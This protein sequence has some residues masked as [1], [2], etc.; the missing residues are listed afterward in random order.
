MATTIP[1]TP[2]VQLPAGAPE[3]PPAPESTPAS[4]PRVLIGELTSSASALVLLIV[5]FATKWYGVAGVPDPSAAR[6]AVSTAETGWEGL[7]L[8]RW[9]VLVT[10]LGALGTVLLHASQRRHGAKTDTSRLILGLG[11]LSSVLLIYRVL[12][13][14]PTGGRVI[15]Q[16]FGALVA[17][18]CALGVALGGHQSIAE[19]RLRAKT[20]QQRSRRRS[21]IASGR[22]NR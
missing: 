10:A 9:V 2:A 21:G 20:V 11:L 1:E 7:E 12:I 22:R 8:V 17:L 14:L 16:K 6:P 3:A 13:V 19:H 18:A 15:D 4:A 5:L